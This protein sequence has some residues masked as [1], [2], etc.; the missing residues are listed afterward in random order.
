MLSVFFTSG[1]LSLFS[2]SARNPHG[3]Q[4][5]ITG[6]ISPLVDKAFRRDQIYLTTRDAS[7]QSHLIRLSSIPGVRKTDSYEKKLIESSGATQHR[8]G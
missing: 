1:L 6:N 4:F 7:C 8:P 5:V 2:S 3:A